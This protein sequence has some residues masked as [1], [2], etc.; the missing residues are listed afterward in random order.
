MKLQIAFKNNWVSASFIFALAALHLSCAKK[1]QPVD[2][3]PVMLHAPAEWTSTQPT[4]SMR[5]AQFTLPRVEGD[6]ED[7]EL[8]IFYFRGEGGS[9]QANLQRWYGQFAQPDSIPSS[10]RAKTATTTVDDMQLTT[11]DLSGTYVA[12]ITPMDPTNRH[13]KPGF[14]ML[15][16]VLETEA[17]P[18]FFKLVGPAKTIEKWSTVFADFVKSAKKK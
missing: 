6:S 17:G 13:N 14:R 9:A 3:G 18:F 10:E 4:S 2:L 15:A 5:K 16:A 12:P 7:G 8:V 1:S 11:V